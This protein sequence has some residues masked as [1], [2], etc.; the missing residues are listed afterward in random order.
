M[1]TTGVGGG[2]VR[3]CRLLMISLSFM[4]L[5]ISETS[6]SLSSLIPRLSRDSMTLCRACITGGLSV[7]AR[8]TS[9]LY[10][11]GK[12]NLG[13]AFGHWFA[14]LRQPDGVNDVHAVNGMTAI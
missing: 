12:S 10:L 6:G 8:K 1:L 5:H 7:S 14:Y 13:R 3:V 4:I 11:S 9:S 2:I